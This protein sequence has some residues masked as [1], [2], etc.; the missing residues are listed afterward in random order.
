MGNTKS[1]HQNH[2]H[3]GSRKNSHII[4]PEVAHAFTELSDGKG[5]IQYEKFE[6]HIFKS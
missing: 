2:H 1:S 3:T 4:T 5:A 6:V